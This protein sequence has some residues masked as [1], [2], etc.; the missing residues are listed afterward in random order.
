MSESK[1]TCSNWSVLVVHQLLPITYCTLAELAWNLHSFPYFPKHFDA[2]IN[3]NRE[4]CLE[5]S[6]ALKNNDTVLPQINVEAVRLSVIY[7]R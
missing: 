7:G 5:F 6:T 2:F 4:T 1:S 3:R